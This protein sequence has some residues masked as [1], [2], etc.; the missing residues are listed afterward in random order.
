VRHMDIPMF[1]GARNALRRN[2]N[3]F[4]WMLSLMFL[5]GT[6]SATAYGKSMIS[7]G[8]DGITCR[9]LVAAGRMA[10]Q[11]PG[12]DWIDATGEAF[13]PVAYATAAISSRTRAGQNVDIDVTTLARSWQNGDGPAGAMFLT[14][15]PAAPKGRVRFHSRES[16]DPTVR[17]VLRVVWTDGHVEE[18][19]ASADTTLHCSTVRSLGQESSISVGRDTNSLLAFQF[20]AQAGRS[21]KEAKLRLV[22]AR[23]STGTTISVFRPLVPAAQASTPDA[24][25][26]KN[27]PGDKGIEK[28]PSVVFTE[29]FESDDWKAHLPPSRSSN[30]SITGSRKSGDFVPLDGRALAVTIPAG[31]NMGLN[32]HYRFADRLGAEPEEIYFRYALRLGDNWDPGSSGGKLPGL[33]GTYGRGGWGGRKATGSN[34]WSTR[35][36]FLPSRATDSHFDQLRGIGSY[37]YHADMRERYGELWGWNLGTGGL[38]RKGRWYSVEQYVRMNT[39]GQNDGALKAWIDGVLV[40]ERSNLRFRDRLDLKIE[41]LWMN[42]WYGGTDPAPKD[43]T[44]YIDNLIVARQYIGPLTGL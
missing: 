24:G 6:S 17:P 18:L 25:F 9:F 28:N 19:K 14:N 34:G 32:A 29:R 15:G 21:I 3:R 23:N 10:W 27:F 20:P 4:A 16:N 38:M 39:L 31:K 33:S 41:S 44:L 8:P 30:A 40:F 11:Q 5:A 35:G 7:D 43:L 12:G 22:V 2:K 13:G 36:A 1:Y 42:V 37:V 26:A